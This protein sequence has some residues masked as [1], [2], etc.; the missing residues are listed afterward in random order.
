ML[1]LPRACRSRPSIAAQE[2]VL[3]RCAASCCAA[4]SGVLEPACAQK[5]PPT[6]SQQ[7]GRLRS[8]LAG[9]KLVTISAPGVLFQ[10][11]TAEQLEVCIIALQL[12][13]TA[14]SICCAVNLSGSLA[15]CLLHG[16]VACFCL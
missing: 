4:H 12:G 15:I 14:P 16:Y 9:V 13:I 8:Q 1:H 11:A 3:V 6:S 10:E 2:K 5:G 7:A